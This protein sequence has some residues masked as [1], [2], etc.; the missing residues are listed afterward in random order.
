MK[1][2]P[3]DKTQPNTVTIN[4]CQKPKRS[5]R[6]AG[7]EQRASL[8]EHVNKT[9]NF[10][11]TA[12]ASGIK[13]SAAK[14]IYY[15]HRKGTEHA[16]KQVHSKKDPSHKQQENDLAHQDSTTGADSDAR[17]GLSVTETLSDRNP[18]SDTPQSVGHETRKTNVKQPMKKFIHNT[19]AS[20]PERTLDYV[21]SQ[22]QNHLERSPTSHLLRQTTAN[23]NLGSPTIHERVLELRPEKMTNRCNPY[24]NRSSLSNGHP[25]K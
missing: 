14:T 21:V 9:E 20:G 4:T 23:K 25:E 17:F 16:R 13:Q 22:A 24:L 7:F 6:I 18:S 8:A 19:S 15:R 2:I 5:Q 3:G 12:R 11:L 10:R 1:F